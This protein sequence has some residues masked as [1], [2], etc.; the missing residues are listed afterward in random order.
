[1]LGP[2]GDLPNP[3]VDGLPAGRARPGAGGPP[4][5]QPSGG[6]WPPGLG[7]AAGRGGPLVCGRSC[8]LG[9]PLG[10]GLPGDGLLGSGRAPGWGCLGTGRV[11]SPPAPPSLSLWRVSASAALAPSIASGSRPLTAS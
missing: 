4:G 2:S 8:G 9:G 3:A 7:L 10:C 11:A 1:V 6:G 5:C